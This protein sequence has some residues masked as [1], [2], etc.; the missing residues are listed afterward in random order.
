MFYLRKCKKF[1]LTRNFNLKI[2]RKC[3]KIVTLSAKGPGK[4]QKRMN[5]IF[6]K[7]LLLLK[8]EFEIILKLKF[9]TVKLTNCIKSKVNSKSF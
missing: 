9:V 8:E 2:K 7:C 4:W 3:L 1:N 5:S 6:E